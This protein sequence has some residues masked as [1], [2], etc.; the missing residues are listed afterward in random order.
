MVKID[1]GQYP[2]LYSRI[3][4]AVEEDSPERAEELDRLLQHYDGDARLLQ[5]FLE[6]FGSFNPWE[7]ASRA[8]LTR[9]VFRTP[10][11]AKK[12]GV[13]HGLSVSGHKLTDQ[14]FFLT[15]R[16]DP[17]RNWV[18]GS[19]AI[20]KIM[21]A[22]GTSEQKEAFTPEGR[23]RI[24]KRKSE[25]AREAGRDIVKTLEE[26][27]KEPE[28]IRDVQSRTDRQ[29]VHHILRLD[30]EL[31]KRLLM[32]DRL[33]YGQ[34]AFA[35]Q[36]SASYF[37]A[38]EPGGMFYGWFKRKLND[39]PTE[40][41]DIFTTVTNPLI[42]IS[43]E[44]KSFMF[45]SLIAYAALNMPV[46]RDSVI[47]GYQKDLDFILSLP[48]EHPIIAE[49]GKP[50]LTRIRPLLSQSEITLIDA[51][52]VFDAYPVDRVRLKVNREYLEP[53]AEEFE[54]ALK[55][56]MPLFI[57]NGKWKEDSY[58]ASMPMGRLRK[59]VYFAAL[60]KEELGKLRDALRLRTISPK[61]EGFYMAL[62][63]SEFRQMV[64]N[65]VA[66]KRKLWYMDKRLA[67]S[68]VKIEAP[69]EAE[70]IVGEWKD[71]L[72]RGNDYE[73]AE[74]FALS[75]GISL[76]ELIKR[77]EAMKYETLRGDFWSRNKW[78]IKAEAEHG[79]YSTG[80]FSDSQQFIDR[81][82]KLTPFAEIKDNL[83]SSMEIAKQ[84][85]VIHFDLKRFEWPNYEYV[86]PWNAEM[87]NGILKAGEE[88]RK[89]EEEHGNVINELLEKRVELVERVFYDGEFKEKVAVRAKSYEDTKEPLR[90]AYG[91]DYVH[92]A[93]LQNHF[94]SINAGYTKAAELGQEF[95]E[96]MRFVVS[97]EAEH[98]LKRINLRASDSL[99]W[100]NAKNI[101]L[102][103]YIGRKLTQ[104]IN[105]VYERLKQGFAFSEEVI[106]GG[107]ESFKPGE[108]TD[109]YRVV[110]KGSTSADKGR[111]KKEFPSFSWKK[112]YWQSWKPLPK[113]AVGSLTE[114]ISQYNERFGSKLR[115]HLSKEQVD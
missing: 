62:T 104:G 19:Q 33:V 111:L 43:D 99:T 28:R 57:S 115:L 11:E 3:K 59:T 25:Q 109:K 107:L 10:D 15:H 36:E 40:I 110:I 113:A 76:S 51:T 29:K 74:N 42:E 90:S 41:R 60:T 38:A 20:T 106:A 22:F 44:E 48:E 100:R 47:G 64:D 87:V 72:F 82:K 96:R 102:E 32:L 56:V 1:I 84:R 97:R 50:D 35:G 67:E 12:E 65:A 114:Q 92:P 108:L 91:L 98:L 70:S 4:K 81:I 37:L 85:L 69:E 17:A 6:V 89:I 94:N 39:L 93:E 31:K 30:E 58:G 23:E 52:R 101:G 46:R 68:S 8:R 61:K 88:M 78:R 14:L 13:I 5:H 2:N 34:T 24:A 112:G 7:A 95:L 103:D 55:R 71:K 49:H 18:S 75:N 21:E 16:H 83:E 80:A 54:L 105:D 73:P 79:L 26:V 63:I 27:L 9:A 86:E 66:S 45:G 53:F 77:A